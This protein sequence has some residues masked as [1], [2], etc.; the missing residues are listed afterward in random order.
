MQPVVQKG[1]CFKDDCCGHKLSGTC[2]I[3]GNSDCLMRK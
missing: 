1:L 3:E 2:L